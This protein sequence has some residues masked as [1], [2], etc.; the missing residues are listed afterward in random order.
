MSKKPAVN[1]IH[2]AV[3]MITVHEFN[4]DNPVVKVAAF[5]LFNTLAIRHRFLLNDI[6][7][8]GRVPKMVV[9]GSVDDALKTLLGMGLVIPGDVSGKYNVTA[10]GA[11]VLSAGRITAERH[12]DWY[13]EDRMDAD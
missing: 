4:Y 3:D 12:I 13:I 10:L 1:V 7:R 2:A 6:Q 5:A 8:S 11:V 9:G